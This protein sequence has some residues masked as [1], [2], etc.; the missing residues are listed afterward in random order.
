MIL[1]RKCVSLLRICVSH[2]KLSR[3]P[4]LVFYV[5]GDTEEPVSV[6]LGLRGSLVRSG[7]NL[8]SGLPLNIS[9]TLG[10]YYENSFVFS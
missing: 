8:N 9:V 4:V 3:F 6:V 10:A 2:T 1:K 7:I 5:K